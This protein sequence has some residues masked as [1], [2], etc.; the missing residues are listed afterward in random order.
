[1]VKRKDAKFEDKQ[2]DRG[3]RTA[4]GEL[5]TADTMVRV[6]ILPLHAIGGYGKAGDVVEMPLEL[7]RVYERNGYVEI[8]GSEQ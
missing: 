6:R 3:L 5:R 4:E 7:A 1:M 8:L 2:I